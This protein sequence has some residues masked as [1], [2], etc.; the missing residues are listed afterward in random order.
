[1]QFRRDDM[2]YAFEATEVLKEPDRR[3]DTFGSTQFQFVLLSEPMDRVGEVSVRS[4][5]L[6]AEKPAILRP[7]L[8]RP[9]SMAEFD[10]EGF[11]ETTAAKFRD[12]LESISHKVAFLQYGFQF[13]K[14]AVTVSHLH[15]PLAAVKARVLE[16]EKHKPEMAVILGVDDTWELC[17]LKFTMEMVQKS[18]GIN[19][20]D[21]KR[22]RLL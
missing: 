12:F 21:F 16:E 22:R 8:L 15:E 7:A 10:F 19:I 4:G 17:L 20:F 6:T 11:D 9:E 14:N 13:K 3:I 1:M 2:Q 18:H 5:Y